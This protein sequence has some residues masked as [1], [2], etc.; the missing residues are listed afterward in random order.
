MIFVFTILIVG[1]AGFASSIPIQIN[2]AGP[3]NRYYIPD[4]DYDAFYPDKELT[5]M[6]VTANSSGLLVS[7]TKD[8]INGGTM[9]FIDTD[10]GAGT[11]FTDMSGAGWYRQF[12]FAGGFGAE[13][14]A[15]GW[16]Q[17]HGDL[18]DS[19]P[20]VI[21]DNGGTVDEPGYTFNYISTNQTKQYYFTYAFL[22]G[23]NVPANASIG[24]VAL[25]V[26]GDGTNALDVIPS[27]AGIPAETDTE[28]VTISHF[29]RIDITDTATGNLAGT[30]VVGYLSKERDNL[31]GGQLT[32]GSDLVMAFNVWIHDGSGNTINDHANTSG[33]VRFD[34]TIN[35]SNV[36]TDYSATVYKEFGS[37]EGLG[38]DS[39]VVRIPGTMFQEGDVVNWSVTALKPASDISFGEVQGSFTV[40]PLPPFDITYVGG[41]SPTGGF[42]APNQDIVIVAQN[43]L[44]FADGTSINADPNA[45]IPVFME[46]NYSFNNSQTWNKQNMTWLSFENNNNNYEANLGSYS[47][48]NVTFF[49]KAVAFFSENGTVRQTLSQGNFTL[50]IGI[51][52]P[53]TLL[54]SI[55]DP[56]GD[57]SLLL[58]VNDPPFSEG[59]IDILEFSVLANDFNIEFKLKFRNLTNG[60]SSSKGFS[61]VIF[62][63]YIDTAEGGQTMTLWNERVTTATGWEYALKADGFVDQ[64]F[65]SADT[66]NP[67][68]GSGMISFGNT[69]SNE[70]SIVIP[71]DQLGGQ[72]Q[73][74]WKY[75][76]MAGSDDFNKFRAAGSAHGGDWQLGG[77]IDGETDP[78]VIDMLVPAGSPDNLQDFLLD[79]YDVASNT[80]ATVLPVG[81]NEEF[82]VDTTNPDV[83]INVRDDTGALLT[84]GTTITLT[85]DSTSTSLNL[86]VSASDADDAVL[87]GLDKVQL[88]DGNIL[89]KEVDLN[90]EINY[91]FSISESFDA[92]THN[93]K[94]I[95]FDTTGN[96]YSIVFTVTIEEA[97][98]PTTTTSSSS[99]P[100]SSETGGGGFLPLDIAPV[101]AALAIV[102][103][104]PTLKKKK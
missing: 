2:T 35:R 17:N 41:I 13:Y 101:F 69:T 83:E 34:Y 52:P 40:A 74:T 48:G 46:I 55:S 37:R 44:Q 10:P 7:L 103:L 70:A 65:T 62:S 72:P 30:P 92:G 95:A 68:A 57:Y 78:N 12:N 36:L 26:G 27:Q 29:L 66:Q 98:S 99:T 56:S 87:A 11:G 96:F 20:S 88:F 51:E 53:K 25:T 97:A 81:P 71:V 43:N 3:A 33:I 75:Y 42:V 5:Q 54:Y 86:T 21:D 61:V 84:N 58:P 94:A 60:F 1:S 102:A 73:D 91:T 63:I 14:W 49:I 31:V 24:L 93:F 18:W 16:E 22:F 23:A 104:I 67:V 77:G 89:L 100:S 76:V 80:L 32:A 8:V 82:V 79:Q 19:T 64:F 6:I 59:V 4:A 9:L 45:N 39:H 28:L 50:L 85:E 47:G 90:G 15:A 38:S